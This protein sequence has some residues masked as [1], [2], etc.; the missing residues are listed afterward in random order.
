MPKIMGL[1]EKAAKFFCLVFLST[2]TG[3]VTFNVVARYFFNYGVPWCEE[4]I[5]YSVII[6]TFF[7]LS[8]AVAKNECMKIDLLLQLLKGKP[9]H[10]VNIVGTAL[11]FLTVASFVVFSVFLVQETYATG[12]ITPSTDFPMYMPYLMVTLGSLFCLVRSV[13]ALR[14]ALRRG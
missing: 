14:E 6:A 3:L 4:A 9:L 7:G 11:E 5:R 1:F 2:A 10:A 12:Q 8:L 13:Q